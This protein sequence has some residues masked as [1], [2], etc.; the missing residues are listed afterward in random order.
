MNNPDS[1]GVFIREA[2]V[3]DAA[4]LEQLARQ[5]WVPHYTPIIG[6]AQ[7]DYMLNQFQSESAIRSDIENGYIY[8]IA[9]LG[10]E[11]CGYSAVRDDG[12]IHF[13]SKLYV[14]E[15]YRGR[16]IAR[17]LV[18]RAVR[19]A[20][21]TG[22]SYIRLTCN[23]NNA[24]SLAAYARLGFTIA[25]DCATPIGAGFEMDDYILEKAVLPDGN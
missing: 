21:A 2:A 11:A 6:Y 3:S 10:G 24:G 17:A 12:S 19:R 8:D 15:D 5:I 13:L 9:F 18:A 1:S 16:G 20:G 4:L 7:V 22:A 25:E 14:H 23:K